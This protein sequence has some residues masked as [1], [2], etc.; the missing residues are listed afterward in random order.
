MN[1]IRFL[2][3]RFSR[4]T[5]AMLLA[6][7]LVHPASQA[8]AA[9]VREI[10]YQSGGIGS[11]EL[12]EMAKLGS[13]YNLRV[14]FAEAVTGA[15]VAGVVVT[16]SRTDRGSELQFD[17]CGP[18]F[19][20]VVDPGTYKITATY[21]GVTRSRTVQVGKGVRQFTLYWPAL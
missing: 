1:N 9:P 21:E 18:L 6:T 13:Q 5:A 4:A 17:D 20:A 7:M 12:D 8:F 2:I 14:Q 11:E 19:Y 10:I 3:P 15:Y 16:I